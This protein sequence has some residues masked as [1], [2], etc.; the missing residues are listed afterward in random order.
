MSSEE[1]SDVEVIV[2]CLHQVFRPDTGN[3]GMN[4]PGYGD[5]SKCISDENNK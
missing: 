1:E 3:F 2:R 4:R 5:C